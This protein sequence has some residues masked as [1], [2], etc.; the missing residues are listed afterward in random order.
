MYLKEFIDQCIL[1]KEKGVRGTRKIKQILYGKECA[2]YQEDIT[3][4]VLGRSKNLIFER[5]SYIWKP[6]KFFKLKKKSL[7]NMRETSSKGL[8]YFI[9]FRQID[10]ER[11]MMF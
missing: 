1:Y 6:L 9:I 8:F 3:D 11:I 10:L 5:R 7:K 2:R 4:L